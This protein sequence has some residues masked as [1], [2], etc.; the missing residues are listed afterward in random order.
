MRTSSIPT[1]RLLTLTATLLLAAACGPSSEADDTNDTD[2]TDDTDGDETGAELDGPLMPL[3]AGAQWTYVESD[4]TGAVND[5]D[6][7]V[8]EATTFD[9]ADALVR[10]EGSR[11]DTLVESG[12]AVNRRQRQRI[13]GATLDKIITYDPGFLRVD[14][15]WRDTSEGQVFMAAFHRVETDGEG[16]N[17]I[18][19]DREYSYTLVA[20][21][22]EVEVSA[23][24]FSTVHI[25][26]ECLAGSSTGEIVEFWYAPGVG[27]I[28]KHELANADL[29]IEESWQK[30]VTFSIPGGASS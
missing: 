5:T 15:A 28:Q 11:R 26:R 17:P 29:E 23:G 2:D 24:T 4:G 30:L 9:G 14:E 7:V 25:E 13:E 8:L 22:E 18:E 19:E 10:S 27:M 3:V 6:H 16:M 12:G 1:P 20:T 21:D